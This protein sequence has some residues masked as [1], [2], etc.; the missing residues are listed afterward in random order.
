MTDPRDWA[1]T[2][3]Q[4]EVAS[5]NVALDELAGDASC[6]ASDGGATKSMRRRRR[7]SAIAERVGNERVERALMRGLEDAED[8]EDAEGAE[9]VEGVEDAEDAE[10]MENPTRRRRGLAPT[11]GSPAVKRWCRL[12]NMRP[13]LP[14]PSLR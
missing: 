12:A 8:A 3:V 5:G 4:N 13:I 11:A 2:C 14:D 10:G 1:W 9:G 6:W 7:R